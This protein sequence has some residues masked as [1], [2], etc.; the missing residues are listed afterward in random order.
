MPKYETLKQVCDR[1]QL[2]ESTIRRRVAEGEL[3]AYKL[4]RNLRFRT[5][6]IDA[7][8]AKFATAQWSA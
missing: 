8:V 3:N 1:T 2:S 7:W 4:G 6:E 5:D